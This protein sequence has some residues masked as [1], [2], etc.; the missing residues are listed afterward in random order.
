[1]NGSDQSLACELGVATLGLQRIAAGVHDFKVTDDPGA[2]AVGGQ[3]GGAAGVG[4][5]ALLG[6]GLLDKMAN[7]GQAVLDIAKSHINVCLGQLIGSDISS[8]ELRAAGGA[9]LMVLFQIAL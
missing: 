7:A 2:V 1:M 9:T 8:I 6:G 3:A 5:G 4:D